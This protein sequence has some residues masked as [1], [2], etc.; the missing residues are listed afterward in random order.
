MFPTISKAKLFYTDN[1]ISSEIQGWFTNCSYALKTMRH[2]IKIHCPE[3]TQAQI[4]HAAKDLDH[5]LWKNMLNLNSTFSGGKKKGG[6]GGRELQLQHWKCTVP[7]KIQYRKQME[8]MKQL[9]Y[10]P[11]RSCTAHTLLLTYSHMHSSQTGMTRTVYA[12]Q[13]IFLI[14]TLKYF[15][16]K[17]AGSCG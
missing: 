15:K 1:L 3:C 8:S 9:F 12:L 10:Y 11:F 16:Q 14:Y 17:S 6:E 5:W 13:H 7:K 4:H 2:E